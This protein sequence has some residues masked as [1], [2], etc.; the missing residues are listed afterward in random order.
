MVV[1]TLEDVPFEEA[2][3]FVE[4]LRE[5][6]MHLAGAIVNKR[7]PEYLLDTRATNLARRLVERSKPVERALAE[8]FLAYRTLG[9]RDHDLMA[10]IEEL[11][12]P[13]L[14]SVPRMP[15]PVGDLDGLLEVAELLAE[16]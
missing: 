14:G 2:R 15:E 8:N 12:V 4:K 9:Q 6:G 13:L 16:G 1:T 5:A 3:F 7:L 10:R 11:G